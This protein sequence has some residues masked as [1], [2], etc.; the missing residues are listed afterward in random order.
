MTN[1]TWTPAL[2]VVDAQNGFVTPASAHVVPVVAEL[3][4]SWLGT[5]HPVVFS[6]YFN[7]ADSPYQRLMGWTGLLEAP[8]TDIVDALT[9]FTEHPATHVIDKS[10][11]TALTTEGMA[12]LTGL[13]ITD[14]MV[15]GIDTDGCVLKTVLDA[16]ESGFTPWVLADA[17]ASSTTR[18]PAQQV[19]DSAL[20]LMS[21]LIGAGQIIDTARA[22]D[23]VAPPLCELVPIDSSSAPVPGDEIGESPRDDQGHA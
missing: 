1:D 13:G 14:V 12:L 19:H 18:H 9:P 5:N 20:L 11:Y 3:V 8:E 15:C 16:F 2:L 10:G 4:E 23:R 7:Y 17:C 6:R 22:L 21:R